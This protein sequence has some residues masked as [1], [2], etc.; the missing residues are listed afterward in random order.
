MYPAELVYRRPA[1]LRGVYS[2][3]QASDDVKV[4]AGGQSLLP[5]MKL[6]LAS[7]AVLVDLAGAAA[8][9]CGQWSIDGGV[10][11]GALTTYRDLQRS[12]QTLTL[13]PGL[14]DTLR[15]IGDM[16]VRARG[17]VGGSVA[18]G[19][20]TADLPAMLLTLE[21]TVLLGS[22]RGTRRLPLDHFITGIFATDLAED[23]V[24]L[25]IEVPLPPDGTGAAYEKFGHP[26]SHFAL[27]GV[28]AALTVHD[29]CI[30]RARVAMTGVAATPRRLLGLESA[31]MGANADDASLADAAELATEGVEP[32]ADLHAPAPYRLNLLKLMTR[33]ALQNAAGRAGAGRVA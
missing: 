30:V 16:Q 21:T 15:V 1:D 20:P 28:A 8:E 7:P 27:C 13:L 29:G 2:L 17:T 22:A 6:R 31:L 9:L 10:R 12:P 23:E 11:I 24:L 5:M 25:A 4:I 19:D 32:L 18:H 33:Q 14:S 26:A 3:L